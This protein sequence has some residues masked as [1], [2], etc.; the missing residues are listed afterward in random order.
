M[1]QMMVPRDGWDNFS[2]QDEGIVASVDEC[3]SRCIVQPGCMQYSLNQEQLCRTRGDLRL[4]KVMRGVALGWIEER[5]S[6]F[7]QSVAPCGSE[8]RPTQILT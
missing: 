1:P 3:R 8:S 6:D 7:E 4:G 5:I 2:D